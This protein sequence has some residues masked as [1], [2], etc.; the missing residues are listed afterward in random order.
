MGKNVSVNTLTYN[1]KIVGYRLLVTDVNNNV[2]Y[3]DLNV[4]VAEKYS[5][6]KGITGIEVPLINY[7]GMLLSKQEK[8]QGVT[9]E[10]M[11]NNVAFLKEMSALKL[12]RRKPVD[13]KA[14]A[15]EDRKKAMQMDRFNRLLR[16][17]LNVITNSSHLKRVGSYN[18]ITANLDNE[19]D[20]ILVSQGVFTTGVSLNKRIKSELIGYMKNI[21]YAYVN[22]EVYKKGTAKNNIVDNVVSKYNP[23]DIFMKSAR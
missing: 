1:N 9:V 18:V 20:V 17:C 13:I 8:E 19:I 11:S 7:G 23:R 14:K 3:Y 6:A 16:V 22:T 2:K 10:D 12:N 21:G 5:L 15:E 4:G